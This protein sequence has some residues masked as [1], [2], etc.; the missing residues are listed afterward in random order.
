M[1]AGAYSSIFIATPLAVQLKELEPGVRAGDARTLRH[2]QRRQADRYAAVPAYTEDLPL[3]EPPAG[4]AGT[5]HDPATAVPEDEQADDWEP[6]ETG[7]GASRSR[8]P[9]STAGE[10]PASRTVSQSAAA[11]R[12]QPSR[13]P[14]SQRGK[15]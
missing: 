13:K 5:G 12:A 2:R 11:K 4:M 6:Q 8:V 9:R 15:R 10:R 3:H 14:R 1:A 7:I